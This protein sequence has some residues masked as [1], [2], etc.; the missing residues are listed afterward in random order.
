M[1]NQKKK[2]KKKKNRGKKEKVIS[3][4]FLNLLAKIIES[5]HFENINLVFFF[6][7]QP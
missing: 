6:F 1:L 5:A 3:H 7:I 4:I 2:K